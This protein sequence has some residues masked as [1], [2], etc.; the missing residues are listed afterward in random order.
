MER[1]LRVAEATGLVPALQSC[2][3]CTDDSW[4]I[5]D[6]LPGRGC[7]AAWSP[8]SSAH[9]HGLPT[10]ALNTKREAFL[11]QTLI[12]ALHGHLLYPHLFNALG[13]PSSGI[14]QLQQWD[15]AVPAVGYGN[16]SNGIWQFRSLTKPCSSGHLRVVSSPANTT[17]CLALVSIIVLKMLLLLFEPHCAPSFLL[18]PDSGL[19]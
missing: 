5:T 18:P 17:C 4:C 2:S 8:H 12:Q 16:S 13:Y 11:V 6:L 9:G 7:S 1:G 15:M 19:V 14:W 10:S 3:Y